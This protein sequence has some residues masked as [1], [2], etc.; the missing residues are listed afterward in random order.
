MHAEELVGVGPQWVR[1]PPLVETQARAFWD[2]SC[3][4]PSFLTMGTSLQ[5]VLHHENP[6][7]H[8]VQ[9]IL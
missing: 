3:L 5:G 4:L 7:A 1:M 6:R 2:F 9:S 8:Q